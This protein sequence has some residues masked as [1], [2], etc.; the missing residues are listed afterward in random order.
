MKLKK[1]ILLL[2][3]ASVFGCGTTQEEPKQD[4]V[5]SVQENGKEVFYSSADK[6]FGEIHLGMPKYM[7]DSISR[8]Q[9]N[10]TLSNRKYDSWSEYSN[11]GMLSSFY[12][13][14]DT[15]GNQ[16]QVN[17]VVD[18]IE[19]VISVKYGAL[20]MNFISELPELGIPSYTTVEHNEIH[21]GAHWRDG[22]KYIALGV[23]PIDSI[24]KKVWVWIFN[25]NLWEQLGEH[26]AQQEAEKF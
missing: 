20:N 23:Q 4:D 21:W 5:F 2:L 1:I 18:E 25:T 3:V 26:K 13:S 6:A 9:P 15:L 16:D 24:K 11:S 10:I 8:T 17:N 19:D 22:S 7:V 14:S 12:L